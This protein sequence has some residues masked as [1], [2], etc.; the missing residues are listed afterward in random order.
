M[1]CG[2]CR[3]DGGFGG[4]EAA[5]C[6]RDRRRN[7]RD[8]KTA[9]ETDQQRPRQHRLLARRIVPATRLRYETGRAGAQEVERAEDQIE[10]DGAR[11]QTAERRRLSQ[12]SDDGSVDDA[13]QGRR[14]EGERRRQGDGKDRPV[15]QR[16]GDISRSPGRRCHAGRKSCS[17]VIFGHVR[18][19]VRFAHVCDIGKQPGR[20]RERQACGPIAEAAQSRIGSA[21]RSGHGQADQR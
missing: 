6:P 3:R 12:P 21:G 20:R 13:D 2:H 11:R 1:Y 19:V 8:Q 18:L 9:G 14:H 16:R 15:G 4:H 10:D 5:A 17:I 7:E